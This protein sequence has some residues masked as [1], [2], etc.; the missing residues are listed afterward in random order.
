MER[1]IVVISII[2][3]L[4]VFSVSLATLYAQIRIIEANAYTCL[5]AVPALIPLFSSFGVLIGLLV[6]YILAPKIEGMAK[7][8]IFTILDLLE[9]KER[10]VIKMIIENNGEISQAKISSVL[11]KVESHRIIQKLILR[12]VLEKNKEGKTNKIKLKEK[13]KDIIK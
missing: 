11:G 7:K 13:F 6:Y 12:G 3:S 2:I 5:F 1:K 10:D 4:F 8:K 9:P